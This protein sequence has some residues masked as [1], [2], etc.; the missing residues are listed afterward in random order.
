L[1]EAETQL[2]VCSNLGFAR[3]ADVAPLMRDTA[4]LKRMLVGLIK[5]HSQ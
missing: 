3:Q 4:V 5:H 1:S 2:L